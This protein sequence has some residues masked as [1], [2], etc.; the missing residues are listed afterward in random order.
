MNRD[1]TGKEQGNIGA[2]G[3]RNLDAQADRVSYSLPVPSPFFP[4]SFPV[5]S[6][7][8]VR[9][10]EALPHELDDRRQRVVGLLARRLDLDLGPQGGPEGQ[11]T[12]DAFAVGFLAVA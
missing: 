3:R 12:Q 10:A 7:G 6:P 5:L 1:G 2:A 11:D 9:F 8:L 4:R